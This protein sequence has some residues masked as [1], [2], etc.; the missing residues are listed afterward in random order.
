M[1]SLLQHA[2]NQRRLTHRHR[3]L[4][5]RFSNGFNIHRLK[6]LFM[7][8]RAR[9]LAGDAQNG[10]RVRGGRI[11]SGD[12]IR[13]GRAGGPQTD[14]DIT[15]SRAGIAFSHMRRA[16]NMAGKNMADPAV[17]THRRIERV[18]SRARHAKCCVNPFFFQNIHCRVNGSH[19]CHFYNLTVL[20][21]FSKF[22]HNQKS[23][24]QES[25]LD[26]RS[27]GLGFKAQCGTDIPCR[28]PYQ[29]AL[30]DKTVRG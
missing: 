30:A 10:N 13:T 8:T 17:L 15:G 1:E 14:T 7:Q 12:H 22:K 29:L 16:F 11:Q 19:F 28:L 3:H 24:A 21:N 2:R 27:V 26:R 4:G 20:E 6:V 25:G 9:R 18:N 5:D 23:P